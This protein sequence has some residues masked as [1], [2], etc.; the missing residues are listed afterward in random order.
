MRKLR[1]EMD[2]LSVESFELANESTETGT[3]RGE[4]QTYTCQPETCLYDTCVD[5]HCPTHRESEAYYPTCNQTYQG[6]T[7]DNFTC[8]P[9]GCQQTECYECPG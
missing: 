3:V 2:E 7:C 5:V 1:L 6:D 4:Q 8:L 9:T